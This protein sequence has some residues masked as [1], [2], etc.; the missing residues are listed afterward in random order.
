MKI[1]F[2]I[3]FLT[4][5]IS[6]IIVSFIFFGC[7]QAESKLNDNSTTQKIYPEWVKS[8]NIYEVNIRQF[9]PEGNFNAFAEHL[10]RLKEMGVDILWLMPIH[11]IGIINRK[12]TLGSY[13]SVKD[14]RGVNP[15]YGNESDF[16]MLVE[17]AHAL[18]M[19]VIIDWVA[20][21]TAWDNH[22]VLEHPDWYKTDTLGAMI[23]PFDWTDVVA[24]DFS[25]P[26][27]RAYMTKSMEYWV[28]EY[29][30]DGFRCDVAGMVPVHF[31]DSTRSVLQKINP[32]FLL[33]EAEEIP[34]IKNAFDAD[35]AWKL[36]HLMNEHAKGKISTDSLYNYIE[37]VGSCYPSH[38][39]Q[40]NFTSNHDEN[41]WNGTEYERYGSNA[42]AYAVLTYT[43][44]GMP[45]VYNG[46]ESAMN[47]R[48][49]FFEKDPIQWGN[50]SLNEFY[51]SLN[52]LKKDQKALWNPPFGGKIKR[53]KGHQSEN[54][55]G[56]LRECE[57][58][59]VF[60]IINFGNSDTRFILSEDISEHRFQD[61]FSDNQ[62][63][64]KKGSEFEIP[65]GKYAIYYQMNKTNTDK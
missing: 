14:Y 3:Q 25:K 62:S 11:P 40:M 13:Y 2:K 59:Q 7:K 37:H 15:E 64:L 50:Y 41:S 19:Y 21:H 12:G 47:H 35:Y 16:K 48:L 1:N 31:W 38:A 54:T 33:A 56:Y 51:S 57:G 24:L 18:G 6:L 53:V 27:L 26:A 44:P 39:F 34:L 36:M 45:L 61:L 20:N 46:M 4:T 42:L 55:L 58:C 49:A 52:N 10:P 32:V 60:T 22:L 29:S 8:A 43:I 65:A 30:I 63:F 28:N 17:K 23:S 9:T 5:I